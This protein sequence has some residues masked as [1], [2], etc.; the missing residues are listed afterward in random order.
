MKFN[1]IASIFLLLTFSFPFA[2]QD[3]KTGEETDNLSTK[4]KQWNDSLPEDRVYIQC[5][6]PF[7]S[8]G[9]SV[10]FTAYIRDA[11]SFKASSKS[12]IIH[13]ELINPKGSVEKQITIVGKN[14]ISQ[15]DFELTNDIPG[16]LYTLKAYT[17]WQK[18]DPDPAFFI[19]EIQIQETVLPSLKM[20]LDFDKKAYGPGDKVKAELSVETNQNKP[21]SLFPASY[22]VNINGVQTI[23]NSFKG[24]KN[25]KAILTFDLPSELS[26]TDGILNV[27]LD[28]DGRKESISRSIPIVLNKISISFFPEGGDAV[29]NLTSLVAF[30]ALNEFGK[31]AD[32]EGYITDDNNNKVT[33]F[34]SFHRG[35]GAF[36]LTPQKG[37]RYKAHIT[38]PKGISETFDLPEPLPQ[39]YVLRIEKINQNSLK[40]AIGSTRDEKLRIFFQ[41]RGKEYFS[42]VISAGKG[43]NDVSIDLTGMPI[44]VAQITL[45][46]SKEIPRAERLV[47]VNKHKQLSLNIKTDKEKYLPREKVKMTITATDETGMRMPGNFSLTVSDDQLLSFADDKSSTILSHMLLE[48]DV[49]GKIEEPRFYFDP[50]QQKADRALDLLLMTQGWRRFTWRQITGDEIPSI[51]YPSERAII[52]GIVMDQTTNKGV[53]GT[54]VRITELKLESLTDSSGAFLFKNVDLTEP[55]TIEAENGNRRTSIKIN[56]YTSTLQLWFYPPIKYLE[57]RPQAQYNR[58]ALAAGKLMQQ[59]PPE[60]VA[61]VM[62]A[63][64]PAEKAAPLMAPILPELKMKVAKEEQILDE[65]LQPANGAP[66]MKRKIHGFAADLLPAPIKEAP[67]VV[68]YR[69]REY[70]APDYKDQKQPYTRND[71]RST[72]FWKGNVELKNNGTATVEFYTSDAVT[73]FR[74]IAEGFTVD[75]GI[76]RAE[77]VFY[78]EIPFNISAKVPPALITGDTLDLPLLLKNNTAEDLN[79]ILAIK[80]P[81]SLRLLNSIDSTQTIKAKSSQNIICKML[82]ESVKDSSTLSVTFNAKGLSDAVTF[83]LKII[84]QGFPVDLSF[85]GSELQRSYPVTIENPVK[86]SIKA[87]FRAYPSVVSDLLAGIESIL[88]EPYGCFEQA[89]MTSYPNAL[90]LS[91]LK[92]RDDT[93]QK[94]INK[95]E[96]L[97]QKGYKRLIT[98]ETEEKGY[99]WF[100]GAPGHEALTAY[101]LMQFNDMSKISNVV[102]NSMVERTAEWLMSRRDGKGGFLRNPKALDSYGRAD[103]DITNAY[104]VY[105]L[106]EAGRRDIQKELDEAV[107]S[108]MKSNDPYVQ[109]LVANALYCFQD[110]N[111]GDELLK[112]FLNKQE[113]DGSWCGTRHSIT[114]SEGISLKLE[115]TSLACMAIMK[116]KKPDLNALTNGIKFIVQS[117]SGKG[118]FGATQSTI[119]CLKALTQYSQFA[120]RTESPG[121]IVISINGN[122]AA[123]KKYQAGEREAIVI[124]SLEKFLKEG[125]S[126]VKVSFEDTKNALPFSLS[127]SYNTWQPSTDEQCKVKLE[128]TISANKAK[129]GQTVRITTVLTNKT[130]NGLPMTIA[131]LGLPAGVSAQPWQ[132]KELQEKKVVDFYEVTPSTVIFYFR[133]MKPEEVRTINLDCKAEVPGYFTAPSSRAYLYYTNEYKAWTSINP[134]KIE[135]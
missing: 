88:Q 50:K 85:S 112:K 98:F 73:S 20:K 29:C 121:T 26:S 92:G 100:G 8:P 33:E 96:T 86:N 81:A 19:K 119:L 104:I 31:G 44:G 107:N 64:L 25:G 65:E 80:L 9:E 123:R 103:Q 4:F 7:Y 53:P 13:V 36:L 113:A 56:K 47:F 22:I 94:I 59:E 72:I 108:A 62:M 52:A 116:S 48:S 102:D 60:M 39:G 83:P 42:K 134:L 43:M 58:R 11:A 84:P 6:K 105:A 79:G 35:M 54:R 95:A 101:G 18:N 129:V 118:G 21:L 15:G 89:S 63:P 122:V 34:S 111:R 91:Y 127:V 66:L 125:T 46:D 75:G 55:K 37:K 135:M 71:F 76:G 115:T 97:L 32:I 93:D 110:F 5:D 41:I 51:S 74:A 131:V 78:S 57:T 126:K 128:T 61:E 1:L 45:F 23:Q 87:S 120:R 68:Y 27:L 49:K 40:M 38:R 133:Q 77:H 82:V 16:G 3:K 10:W 124:D 67:A 24:D 130:N 17:N 99:E 28:Y 106:A 2:K 132:L 114:R 117:R 14:G 70:P 109:A 30:Q 90:I 12:D 69:A